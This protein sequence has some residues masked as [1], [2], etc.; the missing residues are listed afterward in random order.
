MHLVR[1][2]TGLRQNLASE[3]DGISAGERLRP[4]RAGAVDAYREAQ[5]P[6]CREHAKIESANVD[7]RLVELLDLID[8]EGIA[9]HRLTRFSG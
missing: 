8:L 6:C 9:D 1:L 3:P 7:R 4:V 5:T 2:T